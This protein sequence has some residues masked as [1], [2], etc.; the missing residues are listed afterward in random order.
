MAKPRKPQ[1]RTRDDIALTVRTLIVQQTS[2]AAVDI[3]LRE[4]VGVV[5]EVLLDLRDIA[6]P[7]AK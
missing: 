2:P 7:A 5:I 1:P 3:Q 6:S 4:L